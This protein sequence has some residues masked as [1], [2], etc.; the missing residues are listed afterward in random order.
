ME[1]EPLIPLTEAAARYPLSQS[2][3][4]L[5]ARTGKLR[6]VKLGR[7]WFTTAEAV[8]AYLADS[9]LRSKDP[10]KHTRD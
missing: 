1:T 6:A 9:A 4:Q 2:H 8:E 10:R 5:L 7:D 3:L